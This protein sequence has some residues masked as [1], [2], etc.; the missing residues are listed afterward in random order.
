MTNPTMT[1]S[2]LASLDPYSGKTTNLRRKLL[3]FQVGKLNLA[4]PVEFV[5]KILH[6]RPMEGSGTTAVGLIHLDDQE[7]TAIDL[8]KRL[9]KVSQTQASGRQF[10]ILAKN[11]IDEQFGILVS[12]TPSLVDLP[13][14]QIRTLPDSYRR[15]DTLDMASHVTRVQQMEQLLTVFVLDVDRL[16]PPI[17]IGD[18]VF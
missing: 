4:L 3:I 12:Q 15:A 14:S 7:I 2:S 8:H 1:S 18:F 17:G 11:S 10:L 6:Y 9:F 13:L 5:Q 16:V